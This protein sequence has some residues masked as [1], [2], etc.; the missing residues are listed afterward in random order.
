MLQSTACDFGKLVE[1][2]SSAITEQSV[3]NSHVSEQLQ[4][5]YPL[6]LRY[7][8][9]EWDRQIIKA[10]T[11]VITSSKFA[12]KRQGI[13]SCTSIT[14][15]ANCL[16]KQL[17]MYH[18]L[19]VT[20]QTVRNDMITEQQYRLYHRIIEAREILNKHWTQR[21]LHEC[22][23]YPELAQ[24]LEYAFGEKDKRENDG[25]G[26]ESDP[27][28]TDGT[29]YKSLEIIFIVDNGPSDVPS[30]N[31]VQ[32]CLVRLVKFMKLRRAV[33]VSYAEYHSKINFVECVH[34]AENEVLS[35]HGSLRPGP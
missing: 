23:E 35:K 31:L 9:T 24:V 33:Q 17:T 11:A 19:I 25:G 10:L 13:Q 15:A 21:S 6:V 22:E 34:S 5:I 4:C 18:N 2:I 28:L 32:M 30:S 7:A 3:V 12:A 27:H 16:P 1:T 29:L 8:D 20:S 26:L 14:R